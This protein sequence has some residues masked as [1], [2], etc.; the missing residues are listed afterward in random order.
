MAM[1]NLAVSAACKHDN[2][3]P[4]LMSPDAIKEVTQGW[5]KMQENGVLLAGVTLFER[6]SFAQ[7]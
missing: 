3:D 4:L 7:G 1:A 2:G 6:Y 5:S